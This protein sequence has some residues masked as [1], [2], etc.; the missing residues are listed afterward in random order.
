MQYREFGKTRIK[1]SVLGFGAM[2]LPEIEK[3]GKWYIDEDKAIEAIHRAFDLG[4][5]Y[6]DTAYGYCHG[7]SEY[8]VGKALKGYEDKVYLS[9]KFPTWEAEKTEDYRRILEEQLK[10]LDR[11]Y[12]D[13]YHFH[14]MNNDR[15]HNKIIKYNLFEEAAKAKAE[16][17]IKYISF[18]FHDKPEVMIKLID[19]G[20]FDTVLCQYNLLNRSNEEAIAYAKS[21]G[22]GTVIMGPV[23]GGR[24][25]FPSKLFQEKLG[26][27]AKSTPELALRF[28][29]ANRNVCCALSG[30]STVEMVEQNARVAS[31]EEPLS[32]QELEKIGDMLKET[33]ELEKLYCTGCSYC[34]PC[35]KGIKIPQVLQT[36]IYHR[37][38][39]LTDYAKQAFSR[40][41]NENNGAHPTDCIECRKCMEKCPQNIDI[42]E[43]LNEA[44]E[45]LA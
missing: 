43:K 38:Y 24:L 14:F 7:N 3:N 22:L 45:E 12:I 31:L 28:V 39:G 13:F 32:E 18:S 35:P 9:T 34:M 44:V 26:E 5:N 37:V 2:R 42:P 25:A 8:V 6:I 20:V 1:I 23:G 11:D 29:M 10:K 17:L 19:T 41:G 27:K 30:M 40:F 36:L 33:K 4:V 21:K 15:Y 16:G